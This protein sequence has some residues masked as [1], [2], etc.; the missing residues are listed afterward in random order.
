MFSRFGVS[1]EVFVDKGMKFHGKYQEM[2][3]KAL[4]DHQ[5]TS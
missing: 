2:C 5:T 1:M 4:I 3:E